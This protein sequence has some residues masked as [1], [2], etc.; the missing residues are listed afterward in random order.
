M[1]DMTSASFSLFQGGII[2]IQTLGNYE[3]LWNVM[4]NKSNFQSGVQM[5]SCGHFRDCATIYLQNK[6][7]LT[8]NV[9]DGHLC[10][11]SCAGRK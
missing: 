11:T 8:G 7:N 3:C 9:S 10:A 1:S 5:L 6:S 2:K 4:L